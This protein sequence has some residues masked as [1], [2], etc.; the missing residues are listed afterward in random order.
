MAS[1]QTDHP[2]SFAKP[3]STTTTDVSWPDPRDLPG[4]DTSSSKASGHKQSEQDKTA[5]PPPPP[6]QHSSFNSLLAFTRPGHAWIVACAFCTASMVAAGRT[7]YSVLLGRIFECVSQWGA[8]AIDGETFLAQVGRWCLYMTLLGLGM[9]LAAGVDVALWVMVGESGARTARETLFASFLK[10]TTAWYDMRENGMSSLMVGIQT[11]TR[12]FQMATSQTLGFLVCDAFIFVACLIVAFVYSWK[13]TLVMLATGV[14]SAVILWFISRFL[15]PAIEAQKRELAQAAQYVTASTTAIDLVKVYKG[16]DHETFRFISAVRRSAKYYTRQVLS[17]CGQMS[18]I[19][20]WM[21]MLFVVGFYFAITLVNRGELTPGNALTTFYAAMIAFQSI[22]ALGPQW[23]ILA[24]GMAAGQALKLLVTELKGSPQVDKITGGHRPAQCFGDIRMTNISFAYPSNPNKI[25]LNPSNFTFPAGHLTFVVGRSGSGKST[26]GNLLLRFYEPLSGDITVDGNSITRL[27]LEWVRSNITLIQQSSILFN[28]SFFKNVALGARDPDNVTVEEARQACSMALLQSTISSMPNGIDTPI[29]P[30]G[31]SLS[32]GQKQ[33]LALA[34]AKLRD[35]PVLILDE[36]TSG[37]DP[38]SR[39]L[40]MEAIRIWRKGKT[41][42]II[43][44]EVGCI[45]DSEYVYVLEDGSVVQE[46]FR[47]DLA[48]DS[49]GFFG[50]LL[51]SA[52]ADGALDPS[53]RTSLA[54]SSDSE[55]DLSDTSEDEPVPQEARYER[56]LRGFN[57]PRTNAPSGL[58]RRMA[59]GAEPGYL[60]GYGYGGG[61]ASSAFPGSRRNSL[62]R[63]NSVSRQKSVTYKDFSAVEQER[64]YSMRLVTQMGLEVQNNRSPISLIS[65]RPLEKK[66]A[67]KDVETASLDSL[68]L[69]FLERLAR[70]KD[71]KRPGENRL[72]S[73]TAIL[74]TVWPALDKKGRLQLILGVLVCLVVAGCNPVFS[75]IFAQLLA[76]FWLPADR[77]AATAYWSAGLASVAVV[78]ATATFFSYFIMEQVAQKWVNTLRAEAIKRILNQPKTWFDKANHSPGRITQCLDRNAEEMRK[79]VGMFVPI[80]LTVSVMILTSLV[81]ALVIRW[82]LTLVTL[83]GVPV[84]MGTARFN[85]TTSDKWETICDEHAVKT[86]TIFTETFSNI[87]VVRAL[88]LEKYFTEKHTQSANA[89]Y[90]SGRKRAGYMGFFYGLYMSITFFLTALVFYYGAMVLSQGQVTVTDVLRIVNLLLFSLGTAVAMLG[91]LPQIA[92]AKSTAIQMLYFANLSHTSSHEAKG[93]KRV[94]TPLPVRMTNLRFAYPSSPNTQVL[95]NI[96]LQ[97]DPGT[98]TAI[99]GA[100]GCGKSTIA[101]LLLRLYDPM[102]DETMVA[103]HADNNANTNTTNTITQP[104]TNPT[105]PSPSPLTYATHPASTLLTST[106]RS[107]MGYVPQH[108]FLFPATVRQNITYGLHDD[109]PLRSQPSVERATRAAGIHDFIVSLPS[110][111]DTLVGEGGLQVSGGQAQRISIAR[112]LVRLPKLLVM[113]EPTSALDAEGAEGVRGVVRDLVAASRAAAVGGGVGMDRGSVSGDDR[114]AVVVITHSKEMMRIVDRLVMVDQGAVVEVG[115]YEELVERGGRFAQLVGG[116][117]W[118]GPG[119]GGQGGEAGRHSERSDKKKGRTVRRRTDV[120]DNRQQQTGDDD[121][122]GWRWDVSGPS[123]QY[124]YY[125]SESSMVSQRQQPPPE[126]SPPPR[127]R[128]HRRARTVNVETLEILEGTRAPPTPEEVVFRWARDDGRF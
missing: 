109:S 120:D 13:L 101:G 90:R 3:S 84:A 32:G 108:P 14:P 71:R 42:I 39:S 19:K 125:Q 6:T 43:T 46:G 116:G 92:A 50:S 10:K 12:E 72:P 16:E 35:P 123:S 97:I 49:R 65:R 25:V 69:F 11:Q 93:N 38:V 99:V 58:F 126:P 47:E 9:W 118:T 27:D 67:D 52:D 28:E 22:E 127:A 54:S 105:T 8:T 96:N 98:S 94:S 26:M 73:L 7:A 57:G 59:L 86:G 44:H 78:D 31:S 124:R 23:L 63:K 40:I 106:L 18:Y 83:A 112:A 88:T 45:E 102:P 79:L 91:N 121:D 103:Q 15:D 85:S 122:D 66:L 68:E 21:M 53:R 20:L 34:R 89:A 41:T 61:A 107:H 4:H 100:S 55:S 24:K 80:L 51:A 62:T 77:Q 33:R 95:R 37:L 110:G 82:D 30:G 75:W 119:G 56:I 111:Y 113:D 81:W 117:A 104:P 128:G 70:R 5:A 2:P 29:G 48:Q 1:F 60:A 64:P 74:R 76:S 87:K 114:M 17:N 36:I 115:E